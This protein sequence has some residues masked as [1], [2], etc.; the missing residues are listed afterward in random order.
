MYTNHCTRDRDKRFLIS[1]EASDNTAETDSWRSKYSHGSVVDL[2]DFVNWCDESLSLS[3]CVKSTTFL[4]I[5]LLLTK[6]TIVASVDLYKCLKLKLSKTCNS[7][8]ERANNE[9]IFLK[10]R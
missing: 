9:C 8:L 7:T 2:S 6:P 1:Y 4:P 10:L 5:S 3:A